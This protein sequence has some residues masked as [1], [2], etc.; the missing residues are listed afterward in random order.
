M[1]L[2]HMFSFHLCCQFSHILQPLVRNLFHDSLH[3]RVLR[4]VILVLVSGVLCPL[5]E[6]DHV[7]ALRD[8]SDAPHLFE[9][10]YFF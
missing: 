2:V 7:L 6:L 10:L 3:H 4:I 5:P 1:T 8:F 9:M